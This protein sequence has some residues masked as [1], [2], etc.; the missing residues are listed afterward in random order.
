MEGQPF[1]EWFFVFWV[2]ARALIVAD[3]HPGVFGDVKNPAHPVSQP[4]PFSCHG[5]YLSGDLDVVKWERSRLQAGTFPPKI[6]PSLDMEGE[7]FVI[8]ESCFRLSVSFPLIPDY[9]SKGIGDDRCNLFFK[10]NPRKPRGFVLRISPIFRDLKRLSNF[11]RSFSWHP[12]LDRGAR[13]VAGDEAD[14]NI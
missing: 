5:R 4:R 11:F 2:K 6:S 1:A 8:F 10:L 13:V 3:C 12:C 7:K 9:T 14:R